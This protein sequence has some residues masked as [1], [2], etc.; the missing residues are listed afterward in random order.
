LPEQIPGRQGKRPRSEPERDHR[1][2]DQ[3]PEPTLFEWAGGLPALTRM[4]RIFYEHYVPR[5]PLLQPLFA[6]MAP[7]H[8]ERVAA[9][10]GE[11]FGGPQVYSEEY[12]GYPH[13]LSQHLG[14][15]ITEA[16]RA[17]WA[18][19][20]CQ[21]ADDAGL[22]ADP[23]FRSAFVSYIEWGSR[24]ARENSQP[25]AR[26]PQRMLVPRWDW[27]TAG[28][29]GSRISGLAPRDDAKSAP[30]SPAAE[31]LSFARH[32]Q[33]LFRPADR[34]SMRWAFDLWAYDDVARHAAG[35]LERV[36]DGSMPCDGAWSEQQVDTF[37]RWVES[38]LPR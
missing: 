27:G 7:D 16:Q 25:G 10:L 4:T 13:M 28:P 6:G 19:L 36:G 14:K 34:Q 23:E 24:I 12:G 20:L 22:P 33:P 15:G 37:R 11:T 8:P 31:P 2:P 38:G 5:D 3:T 1:E 32:I 30:M 35:I 17:R 9:W 26:P 29:P 21:A 18:Q